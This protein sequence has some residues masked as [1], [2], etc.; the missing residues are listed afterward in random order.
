L[1]AF[2]VPF[3]RR[4]QSELRRLIDELAVRQRLFGG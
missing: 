2:L 4:E 1:R 3:G